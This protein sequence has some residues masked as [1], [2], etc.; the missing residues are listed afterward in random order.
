MQT[1]GPPAAL[2]L[3]R[4]QGAGCP[5]GSPP[6][7]PSSRPSPPHSRLLEFSR[8]LASQPGPP[9][10]QPT[11][12]R[13]PKAPGGREPGVRLWQCPLRL[14]APSPLREASS[15]QARPCFHGELAS[16]SSPAFTGL[17]T[18]RNRLG[19]TGIALPLRRPGHQQAARL[20]A[21]TRPRDRPHTTAFQTHF[22]KPTGV[23]GEAAEN[24]HVSHLK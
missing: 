13:L 5:P 14:P 21:L 22:R 16:A 10:P 9:L 1:Q 2:F 11:K 8:P 15:S 18:Q 20:S 3:G 23:W 17:W 12:A 6:G 7:G 24:E 4:G 19:G